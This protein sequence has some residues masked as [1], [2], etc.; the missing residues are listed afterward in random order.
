MTIQPYQPEI[1]FA[2]IDAMGHVNN[3]VY[4]SYFE[5]ARMHFFRQMIGQWDWRKHGILVARNEIDYKRSIVLRDV[6]KIYVGC[7][8]VGTKS[9]TM[10]YKIVVVKDDVEQIVSTG[11]SVLV[12]FNHEIQQ[13]AEVPAMWRE[14]F[15]KL[16]S[17]S[18]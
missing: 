16:P 8:H 12:C 15:E 1:R 17:V 3:A 5:Q 18:S 14:Q 2:D 10:D 6:V 4:L 11:A 13:T 7:K 9:M